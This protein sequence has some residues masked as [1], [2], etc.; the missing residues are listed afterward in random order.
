MPGGTNNVVTGNSVF[1]HLNA[2]RGING[3]ATIYVEHKGD[4]L[5]SKVLVTSSLHGL[6]KQR[7]RRGQGQGGED[8]GQVQGF[9][10]NVLKGMCSQGRGLDS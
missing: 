8:L 5:R 3:S 7:P 2:Y 6:Y 10:R 4:G 1:K 9:K